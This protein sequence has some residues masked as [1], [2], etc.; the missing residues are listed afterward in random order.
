MVIL[1]EHSESSSI[2]QQ[3]PM[4]PTTETTAARRSSSPL[5]IEEGGY[6]SSSSSSSRPP[7]R[8]RR[9]SL[10]SPDLSS[11]EDGSILLHRRGLP[12]GSSCPAS[13][14]SSSSSRTD[15]SLRLRHRLSGA[16][17]SCSSNGGDSDCPPRSIQLYPPSSP[18]SSTPSNGI[19]AKQRSLR[20]ITLATT[21][22]SIVLFV[23]MAS[24][25]AEISALRDQLEITNQHR[26]SLYE[27]HASVET[28]LHTAERSLEEYQVAQRRLSQV[29]HDMRRDMN[30]LRAEYAKLMSEVDTKRE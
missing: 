2:Q 5:F 13:L 27:S 14:T 24:Q 16:I 20:L 15:P 10:S 21:L 17:T 23:V 9:R 30:T 3:A 6:D 25:Q 7:Y 22:I 19:N 28:R 12:H 26:I 18:K 1:V 4:P 29:N 11:D 8:R